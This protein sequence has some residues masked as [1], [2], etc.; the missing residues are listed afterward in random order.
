MSVKLIVLFNAKGNQKFSSNIPVP[1][2]DHVKNERKYN[3]RKY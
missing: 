1:K 2:E 3:S